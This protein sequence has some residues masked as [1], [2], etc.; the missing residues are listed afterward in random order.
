MLLDVHVFSAWLNLVFIIN[1]LTLCVMEN[2]AKFNTVT[3]FYTLLREPWV[4]AKTDHL[5]SLHFYSNPHVT[6]VGGW[7][8]STMH[9]DI[10]TRT[11]TGHTSGKM[12]SIKGLKRAD[13]PIHRLLTVSCLPCDLHFTGMW[14]K[15]HN[16]ERT[17]KLLTGSPGA[18]NLLV[19]PMSLCGCEEEF[20]FTGWVWRGEAD[21][22][23]QRIM[24]YTSDFKW[25][26][27]GK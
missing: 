2:V 12:V 14:E 21:R 6:G 11:R 5:L 25:H 27:I 7:S 20:V 16:A 4:S 19:P 1:F 23:P 22:E 17:C 15:S 8:W 13:N 9:K 24:H 18:G 26:V 3:L 10:G